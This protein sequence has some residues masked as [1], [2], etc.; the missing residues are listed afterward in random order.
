MVKILNYHLNEINSLANGINYNSNDMGGMGHI[1]NITT[2][3]FL[4]IFFC[5]NH[6]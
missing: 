4:V 3:Q 1:F 2:Q 5:S 6:I